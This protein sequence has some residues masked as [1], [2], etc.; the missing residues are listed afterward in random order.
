MWLK[1]NTE[2][3]EKPDNGYNKR[4]ITHERTE[5]TPF[6]EHHENNNSI[7][8]G[9]RRDQAKKPRKHIQ[10]NQNGATFKSMERN[11]FLETEDT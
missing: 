7:V 4:T 9:H 11:R 6:M 8:Q 10:Q 3:L 1:G 2:N 5:H